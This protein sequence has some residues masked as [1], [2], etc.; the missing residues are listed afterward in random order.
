MHCIAVFLLFFHLSKEK[1]NCDRKHHYGIA[2]HPPDMRK[3]ACEISRKHCTLH[4]NGVDKGKSVGY[5]F[6]DAAHEV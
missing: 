5:F 1:K 3:D 4:I 2:E 6:E